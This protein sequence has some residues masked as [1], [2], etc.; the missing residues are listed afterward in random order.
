MKAAWAAGL[1]LW[2]SAGA[3]LAQGLPPA[4]IAVVDTSFLVRE[5]LAGKDIQTQ[6]DRFRGAIQAEVQKDEESLRAQEQEL[7]RQRTVLTPDA[8]AER[9]RAFQQRYGELQRRLQERMRGLERVQ[10]AARDQFSRAVFEAVTPMSQ[11]RGF[12]VVLEKNQIPWARA[13]L[14]I[15]PQVMEELNRR[16]PKIAVPRPE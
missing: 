15:T 13:E 3:A 6:M 16:T 4:V 10:V 2:V 5:S 8:F 11:S 12:N 9:Q 1:A 14:D 7:A